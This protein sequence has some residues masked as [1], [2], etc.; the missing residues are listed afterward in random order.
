MEDKTRK[1]LGM[2]M[3]LI[4]FIILVLNAAEYL[5]GWTTIPI[6]SVFGILLVVYGMFIGGS[7][8]SGQ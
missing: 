5:L 7:K 4:G 6:S 1:K 3:L 2:A 8:S